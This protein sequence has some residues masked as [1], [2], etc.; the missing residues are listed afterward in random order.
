MMPKVKRI[1]LKKYLL[2]IV[3]A[4]MAFIIGG[5]RLAEVS[6]EASGK[7]V[8]TRVI[9]DMGGRRVTVPRKINK[10]FCSNPIGTVDV[11]LLA[12]EKLAGWNFK[13]ALEE[14]KFIEEKYL[15]LPALGVWMG[16]GAVP[17]AEEIVKAAP[18]AILCFWTTDRNGIDMA[19]TIEAQTGIPVILMDCGINSVDKVYELL[20]EYLD[21]KER[22]EMLG[23]YCRNTLETLSEKISVIPE[24]KRKRVFISQGKG[25]LQTDPVG[26]IHIQDVLDFLKLKNVADLPGTAGKGMG[27]PSVSIE[28]LIYWNPDVILINEYN[29]NDAEK[30]GL[31]EEILHGEDWS[32]IKAVR[33]KKVYDIPQSPFS[34]FGKPPSAVRIL[35]SVWLANLLYPDYIHIDIRSEIKRFYSTFYRYSL[36]DTQVEEILAKAL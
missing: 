13:P 26:S 3:L 21:V 14:R 11:Y 7:A 20:G 29:L 5:C 25:G 1:R 22:A 2:L 19:D 4:S 8:E 34:W 30:S 23:R 33:D 10:V 36:T 27:M 17:N 32:Q 31:Y 15:D 12:P 28:Q 9:V 6:N 18:D 16:A 24:Q 35:G